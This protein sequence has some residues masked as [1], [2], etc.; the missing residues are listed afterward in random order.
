MTN[1][2]VERLAR[3]LDPDAWG[4]AYFNKGTRIWRR[5]SAEKS[6]RAI[7]LAMREPNEEML[8]TGYDEIDKDDGRVA[9]HLIWPAMIDAALKE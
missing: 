3:A 7:L 1:P 8:R 2:F 4:A 9:L 5:D 6:V